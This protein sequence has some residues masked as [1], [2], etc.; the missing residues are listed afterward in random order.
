M[1]KTAK[2]RKLFERLMELNLAENPGSAKAL[3]MAGSVVVN[4]QRV[5]KIGF[6]VSERDSIRLK[7]KGRF[8]SRGGDKLSGA[9]EDL[10]LFSVVNDA[11]VLD[12]GSSTGGFTDCALQSGASKVYA[13]DVGTNQLAWNL[14]SDPRVVVKEKTDIRH[15][16][17]AFDTD[18]SLV[19]ADVSF[20]GLKD[21]LPDIVRVCPQTTCQFLLLIKPQFELNSSFVPEGGVVTSETH[22]NLAVDMVKKECLSLG[23][24]L[25]GSVDSRLPGR[26]GN[27]EIFILLV[28]AEA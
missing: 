15:L 14:R 1:S 9:L 25:V 8:V 24:K 6:L 18:I 28:Y 23:L 21:I 27:Q 20:I 7:S 10:S 26:T 13:V 4:E 12:I 22:R 2:K 19:V 17:E 11:V 3:I 16:P 5:D